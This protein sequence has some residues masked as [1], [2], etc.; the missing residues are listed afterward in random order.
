MK[1]DFRDKI[2]AVSIGRDLRAYFDTAVCM[3]QEGL[4]SRCRY[5]GQREEFCP[6]AKRMIWGLIER[7]IGLN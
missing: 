4:C 3:V 6:L 7:M 2:I 1:M 5:A